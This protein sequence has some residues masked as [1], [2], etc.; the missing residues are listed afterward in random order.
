MSRFS[1]NRLH[2]FLTSSPPT[3]FTTLPHHP[4]PLPLYLFPAKF[5]TVL[6]SE[7]HL[8][9]CKCEHTETFSLPSPNLRPVLPRTNMS[10]LSGALRPSQPNPASEHRLLHALG[11]LRLHP[12]IAL[13]PPPLSPRP[14]YTW[15]QS[16]ALP[17]YLDHYLH[18]PS[19][20]PVLLLIVPREGKEKK[21][22]LRQQRRNSDAPE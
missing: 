8:M 3:S 6:F 20:E 21:T 9:P 15:R 17:S 1:L 4:A 5:S 18:S 7:P 10:H 11:L 14:V 12:V 22:K 19:Q 2:L 16:P 13:H